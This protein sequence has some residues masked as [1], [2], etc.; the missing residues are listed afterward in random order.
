MGDQD[1]TTI[2]GLALL[3]KESVMDTPGR[4]AF[5]DGL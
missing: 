4:S 1:M 3:K 2:A 5:A